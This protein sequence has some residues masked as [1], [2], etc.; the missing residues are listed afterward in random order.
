MQAVNNKYYKTFLVKLNEDSFNKSLKMIVSAAIAY[1]VFYHN[2]GASVAMCMIL[3]A[4]FCSPSDSGNSLKDKVVGIGLA[5]TLVPFFSVVL[6]LLYGHNVLF[7]FVFAFLVFTSCIISLYGQKANQLSFTLLMG[8]SL[9]FIHIEDKAQAVENGAYMCLG[10][11]LYLT[12]STI[13]YLVRPSK[14][15]DLVLSE[16]IDNVSAF[17]KIRSELWG[18]NPDFESLKN[19]QL[20]LQVTI[21]DSFAKINQY[22]GGNKNRIINSNE[23]RKIFLAYSFLNQIMELALSTTF[24]TKDTQP[25]IS[26]YPKL[27]TSIKE[28]ILFYSENLH[29]LSESVYLRQTYEPKNDLLSKFEEIKKE[30]TDITANETDNKVYYNNILTYLNNQILKIRSLERICTEKI[31][32]S[33]FKIDNQELQKY[34]KA[35][36][37]RF[38]TLLENL[39]FESTQ[40][41]YAIRFTI[42][43][44]TALLVGYLFTIKKEYWVLLTIVVIMRPGYGLTKSRLHQRI[45]GTLIGGIIGILILYFVTNTVLLMVLMIL[46]MLLGFWLT[47]TDYKIGVT[48]ITLYIIL[49]YGLLKQDVDISVVYRI[50]DTLIGAAISFLATTFIWPSWESSS[51]NHYLINSLTSTKN[52]LLEF[53]KIKS[54]NVTDTIE[55]Q[56]ARQN[57]FIGMGNLMA[58][59]QRLIQEPKNKQKNKTQ[60]YE[61]TALNQTLTDAIGNLE[62]FIRM[63]QDN[64]YYQQYTPVINTI[65]NNLNIC[66]SSF[67]ASIKANDHL[68][69]ASPDDIASL[70]VEQDTQLQHLATTESDEKTKI[71]EA[72]MALSQLN[73]IVNLSDQMAKTIVTIK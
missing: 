73:W 64:P 10:G 19:K 17:L 11:L 18:D 2:F 15:I 68:T 1:F 31:N 14:Y 35:N 24:V 5:A 59:Y 34:F 65:V 37:Y 42:A 47:S 53:N 27:K 43:A 63:H 40:F 30:I 44:L 49:L 66:I 48:F 29:T 8:I 16:S 52:Y 39:N 55:L 21:N 22:L 51:I 67:D 28:I 70:Q 23:N 13:F 60:L 56:N 9:S 6:T 54:A 36:P 61:I 58:S 71:E 12:V 3:G 72:Q 41:R 62:T 33:D 20:A 46:A 4:C 57:A 50:S 26:A 25:Y 38:K 45:L 69:T 32:T 7:Y